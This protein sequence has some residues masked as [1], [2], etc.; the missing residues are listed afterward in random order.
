[1]CGDADHDP[2]VMLTDDTSSHIMSADLAE[3]CHISLPSPFLWISDLIWSRHQVQELGITWGTLVGIQCTM[4]QI[5]A[6]PHFPQWGLDGPLLNYDL[7]AS[8]SH[9]FIT[10]SMC[11]CPR[12]EIFVIVAYEDQAVVPCLYGNRLLSQLASPF[13]VWRGNVIVFGVDV[14]PLVRPVLS[15]LAMLIL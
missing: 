12:R 4:P 10:E 8:T 2:S 15:P 14:D 11:L 1:M 7:W 9:G 6:I 3:A 5:V 13:E